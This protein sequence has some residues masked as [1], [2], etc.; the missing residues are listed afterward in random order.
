MKQKYKVLTFWDKIK[1]PDFGEST[2]CKKN[3]E[4]KASE[5]FSVKYILLCACLMSMEQ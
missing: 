5:L 1:T 2:N 3:V 4:K